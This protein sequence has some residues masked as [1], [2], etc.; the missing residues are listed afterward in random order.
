MIVYKPL[1]QIADEVKVW[2]IEKVKERGH[3]I[4]NIST[5]SHYQGS[6]LRNKIIYFFNE[7]ISSG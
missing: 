6:L 1:K 5:V 2:R 4:I 3:F 7:P